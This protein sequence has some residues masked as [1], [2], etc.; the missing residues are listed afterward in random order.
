MATKYQNTKTSATIGLYIEQTKDNGYISF[1]ASAVW[2]GLRP[3]EMKRIDDND[4][5]ASINVR[6]DRIRNVGG[7]YDGDGLIN[8]IYLRNLTVNSQGNDDRTSADRGLYAFEVDYRNVFSVNR[9][10][11]EKM[12]LSLSKIE[13]RM[14]ALY[15]TYGNPATFGAYLLRVADAIGASRIVVARD[16]ASSYDDCQ[17]R[18][19]ELSSG[20]QHVDGM[21]RT[22]QESHKPATV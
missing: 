1:R 2:V 5:I 11:A 3:S 7:W 16:K 13:K 20:A 9:A 14:Q 15:D 21:V 12:A 22:W 4:D 10:D 17:H 6:G 18:I 8:G 19:M